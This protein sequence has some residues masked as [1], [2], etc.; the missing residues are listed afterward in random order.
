MADLII[1]ED[2]YKSFSNYLKDM[3]ARYYKFIVNNRNGEFTLFN[4]N[5]TQQTLYGHWGDKVS[6][7]FIQ[8]LE[9]MKRNYLEQPKYNITHRFIKEIYNENSLIR[10]KYIEDEKEIV[11]GY[12]EELVRYNAALKYR[13]YNKD[14]YSL[15][16]ERIY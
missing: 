12:D 14:T 2:E 10:E 13:N 15:I 9:L 4:L 6:N 5:Q 7:K 16:I 3:L 11:F 8:N 1:T